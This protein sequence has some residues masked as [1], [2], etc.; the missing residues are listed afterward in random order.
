MEPSRLQRPSINLGATPRSALWF[1]APLPAWSHTNMGNGSAVPPSTLCGKCSELPSHNTRYKRRKNLPSQ[2]NTMERPNPRSWGVP[3]PCPSQQVPG[4]DVR[5]RRP[6][7][8]SRVKEGSRCDVT[9]LSDG[10][11]PHFGNLGK[12]ATLPRL[13]LHSFV[14]PTV[15][16]VQKPSLLAQHLRWDTQPQ[17]KNS[18]STALFQEP[19]DVHVP[20]YMNS[21]VHSPPECPCTYAQPYIYRHAEPRMNWCPFPNCA[22]CNDHVTTVTG[23]LTWMADRDVQTTSQ[24]ETH[25]TPKLHPVYAT[26]GPGADRISARLHN[27]EAVSKRPSRRPEQVASKPKHLS[28]RQRRFVVWS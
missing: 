4:T 15:T 16:T 12:N 5:P 8:L 26:S 11:I 23:Q 1:A 28:Q 19:Q 9:L 27:Q 22:T 20:L 24:I 3:Q 25:E 21:R 17:P 18:S 14:A 7:F 6:G 13:N 2:Q 10:K